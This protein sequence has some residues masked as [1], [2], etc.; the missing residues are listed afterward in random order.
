MVSFHFVNSEKVTYVVRL[1]G[2][3]T[4]HL[5]GTSLLPWLK[6]SIPSDKPVSGVKVV[7]CNFS[8]EDT[9]LGQWH[10]FFFLV[11]IHSHKGIIKE[12]SYTRTENFHL[13]GSSHFHSNL[14]LMLST[15]WGK[16][17]LTTDHRNQRTSVNSTFAPPC[18]IKHIPILYAALWKLQDAQ[19]FVGI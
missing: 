16:S 8:R 7:H 13:C 19:Q 1:V 4:K 15:G 10:W 6:L 17:R 14:K 3:W 12:T 18:Y 11:A 2:T 5:A 9:S